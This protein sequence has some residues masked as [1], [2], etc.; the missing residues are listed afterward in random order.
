MERNVGCQRRRKKDDQIRGCTQ[1]LRE[2]GSSV[3]IGPLQ[4]S[5]ERW[6][7]VTDHLGESKWCRVVYAWRI[8][9]CVSNETI[10]KYI[11]RFTFAFLFRQV[12]Q[13][14]LKLLA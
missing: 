6:R 11:P 12:R 9:F 10:I 13:K 8:R 2:D 7:S 1:C 14:Q 4:L 3:M 5:R